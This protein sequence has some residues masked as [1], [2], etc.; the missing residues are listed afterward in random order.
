MAQ[1]KKN[2]AVIT[3]IVD[4]EEKKKALKTSISQ[5]EKK[6][7]AGAVM[8]LGDNAN[9][10]VQAVSTGS[11]SLDLALGIGGVPRGRIIE[12]FGPESSGKTTVALHIIAEV[13]KTGGEAAF[14]GETQTI[15]C[16][17]CGG[18]FLCTNPLISRLEIA[19]AWDNRPGEAAIK[20]KYQKMRET[21]DILDTALRGYQQQYGE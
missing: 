8:R 3:P 9:M 16:K 11:I 6:Y 12:I 17:R 7:G 20:E 10:E 15:K 13:Q 2:D 1:K 5:I 19:E 18:A 21:A 4:I 14:I